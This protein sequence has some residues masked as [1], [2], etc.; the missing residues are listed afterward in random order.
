MTAVT[1]KALFNEF[2]LQHIQRHASKEFTPVGWLS[3]QL[4]FFVPYIIS[5]HGK[6]VNEEQHFMKYLQNS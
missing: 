5:D 3:L 4:L 6:P 2:K 1:P